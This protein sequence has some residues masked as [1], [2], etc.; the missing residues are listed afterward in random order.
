M[1]IYDIDIVINPQ[2]S[3]LTRRLHH[4]LKLLFSKKSNIIGERTPD[5]ECTV[6][7]RPAAVP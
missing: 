4:H 6:I 1:T 5:A 2:K 7:A 3:D